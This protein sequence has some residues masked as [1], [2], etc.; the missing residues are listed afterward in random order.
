MRV[1]IPIGGD[2]QAKLQKGE[3]IDEFTEAV[4]AAFQARREADREGED[5][6]ADQL[7]GREPYK[8]KTGTPGTRGAAEWDYGEAIWKDYREGRH[9]DIKQGLV[10]ETEKGMGEVS[11]SGMVPQRMEW[12]WAEGQK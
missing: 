9:A 12:E 7:L 4:W 8:E 2:H 10:V 1:R 5:T 11:K 3:E 6:R